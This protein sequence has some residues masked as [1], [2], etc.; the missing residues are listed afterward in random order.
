MEELLGDDETPKEPN[1]DLETIKESLGTLSENVQKLT[2]QVT[3]IDERVSTP[4]VEEEEEEKD[5]SYNPAEK[6]GYTWDAVRQDWIKDAEE[7]V[8]RKLT[9]REEE[10]QAAQ[11]SERQAREF[12]DKEFDSQLE[13]MEKSKIIPPI[14]DK[15]NRDDPGRAARRE[16]FGYAAVLGTTNLKKVAEALNREH[17]RGFNFDVSSGQFV[18]TRTSGIGQTAPV[19]S[20]S[21]RTGGAGRVIS[22]KELHNTSM[23]ELARRANE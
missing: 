22:Y 1:Q 12:I 3:T 21:S 4:P 18:R 17:D 7:I 2:E 20:S 14:E 13:E 11:E 8:D 5:E 10:I 15:D 19:G 23:D 6:P 9:E 16:I